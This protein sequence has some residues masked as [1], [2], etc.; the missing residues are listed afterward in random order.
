MGSPET[1]HSGKDNA[2]REE[3]R[4][5]RKQ[6][7]A[8]HPPTRVEGPLVGQLLEG[9]YKVRHSLDR[10][11]IATIHEW[12]RD[13]ILTDGSI[14]DYDSVPQFGLYYGGYRFE[15]TDRFSTSI[16]EQ[17]RKAREIFQ[18]F[19]QVRDLLLTGDLT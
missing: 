3:A 8:V 6:Y 18:R 1:G 7:R 5:R 13:N 9:R 14:L 17:K 10:G 19:K 16:P 15:D 2:T 11:G 12:G 4:A